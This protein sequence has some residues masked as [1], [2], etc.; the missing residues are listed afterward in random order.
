[1]RFLGLGKSHIDTMVKAKAANESISCLHI[2]SVDQISRH[3][4]NI[5]GYYSR[6][7]Y[8]STCKVIDFLYTYEY[9]LAFL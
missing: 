3:G 5:V 1:M 8:D 7:G 4:V 2:M 6:A 9:T